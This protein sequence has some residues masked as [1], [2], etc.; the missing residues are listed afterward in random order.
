MDRS[1]VQEGLGDRPPCR[2]DAFI[3]VTHNT[4]D[5]KAIVRRQE[6]HAGLVCLNAAPGLMAL[7]VQRRLFIHALDRLGADE[8]VN[9]VLEITLTADR[10]VKAE[11]FALFR[12]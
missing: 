12:P 5:F 4:A 1:R 6:I 10:L 9:E 8:P 11:R 3:L 7:D 2:R